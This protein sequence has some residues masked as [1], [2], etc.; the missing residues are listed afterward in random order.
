MSFDIIL[1][2]IVIA[3]LGATIIFA[4]RL[5]KKLATIYQSREELQEFLKQF[6][7][8]MEKAD[9]G[10]KDLKGIG[11][12]VFKTAQEQ[13]KI[14]GALKEDLAFLNERGEELA[15]RLDNGIRLARTLGKD[16]EERN[17]HP[18]NSVNSLS[19]DEPELVRHLQN[20]R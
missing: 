10:I 5:N 3:C 8:S 18:K 7:T 4:M 12:S 19:N 14:A 15:E 20:V 1:D 16:L 6:T 17:K 11:E 13:M 9:A 2:L